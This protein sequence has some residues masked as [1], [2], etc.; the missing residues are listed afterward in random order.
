MR[1]SPQPPDHSECPVCRAE[2]PPASLSC[3]S[4]GANVAQTPTQEILS[5][6]YLLAELARWEAE[7]VVKPEQS[8]TLREAYEL[9][10]EELR[11]QL[12]VNG[13][14]AQPS[15]PGQESKAQV[16]EEQQRPAPPGYQEGR[17]A[18]DETF[19]YQE[20]VAP[21]PKRPQPREREREPRRT[22]LEK[23][24]DPH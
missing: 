5:L 1:T 23:L 9:K 13:R 24:S 21:L 4:C 14:Q 2:I 11:A 7:G 10:R 22:L 15:A 17:V 16:E 12:P 19:V 18:S 20:T 6:N 8:K 3:G